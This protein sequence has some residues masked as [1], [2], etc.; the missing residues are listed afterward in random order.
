MT[1]EHDEKDREAAHRFSASVQ[2]V[3]ARAMAEYGI[4]AGATSTGCLTAAVR[5]ARQ[6]MSA[7]STANWL[8]DVADAVEAETT[9]PDCAGSA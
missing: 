6:E 3:S 7:E 5:L 4:S 9:P 2:A 1:D 8:R